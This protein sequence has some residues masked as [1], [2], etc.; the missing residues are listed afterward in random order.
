MYIHVFVSQQLFQ[1]IVRVELVSTYGDSMY[2]MV[3]IFALGDDSHLY[4]VSVDHVFSYPC[5]TAP[6]FLILI[7]F[8]Y[9]LYSM[10][11]KRL[12]RSP[13]FNVLP[14]SSFMLSLR[15]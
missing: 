9:K 1:S 5:D 6:S 3:K 13:Q 7:P 2:T 8:C 12:L 15:S 11:L 14:W 10:Q 4:S